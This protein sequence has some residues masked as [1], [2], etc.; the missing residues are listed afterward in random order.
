MIIGILQLRGRQHGGGGRQVAGFEVDA[1]QIAGIGGLARVEPHGLLHGGQ[2]CGALTGDDQ[3]A[4]GRAL[5]LRR[6]PMRRNQVVERRN[7]L[8]L[9]PQVGLQHRLQFVGAGQGRVGPAPPRR[10]R[11]QG[12]QDVA[13]LIIVDR[14]IQLLAAFERSRLCGLVAI[15]VERR[16]ARSGSRSAPDRSTG[17]RRRGVGGSRRDRE[18][19]ATRWSR[20]TWVAGRRKVLQRNLPNRGERDKRVELAAGVTHSSSRALR[21]TLELSTGSG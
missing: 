18:C 15:N 21:R 20:L 8:C 3:H 19:S 7:V 9:I 6:L 12:L 17:A 4:A 13:R 2:P 16:P 11:V 5:Q 14:R 10:V 1:R